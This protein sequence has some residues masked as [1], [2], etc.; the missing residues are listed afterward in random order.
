MDKVTRCAVERDG[1]EAHHARFE[2]RAPGPPARHFQGRGNVSHWPQAAF[3]TTHNRM[4][5]R[6]ELAPR[7][8]GN[9]KPWLSALLP[10]LCAS[11]LGLASAPAFAHETS[12]GDPHAHAA[13]GEAILE[14]RLIAPCCWTQTLDMHESPI[15]TELRAEIRERLGH[16]ENA[17]TIEDDLAAR[18]G[19]RIRAVPKGRDPRATI[20]IGGGLVMLVSAAGL[21]WLVRRWTQR[22]PGPKGALAA[23]PA[24]ARDEYDDRLE[25]ELRR[26][27]A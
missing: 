22:R 15:A 27:D 13:P 19:E 25:D 10:L 5:S 20:S 18:Y 3:R 14:G 6:I 11:I 7:S 9:T 21:L 17:D 26:L 1:E 23:R 2:K 16:G 8:A 12:T 24:T 4:K